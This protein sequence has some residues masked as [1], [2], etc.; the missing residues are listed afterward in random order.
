MLYCNDVK[1]INKRISIYIS[2]LLNWQIALGPP[3]QQRTS[4]NCQHVGHPAVHG[5]SADG[6]AGRRRL[7]RR[8]RLPHQEDV[9]RRGDSDAQPEPSQSRV[10]QRGNA[11]VVR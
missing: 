11:S 8:L 1:M 5:H 4:P 2:K 9:S 3:L 7:E 6:R 10:Q